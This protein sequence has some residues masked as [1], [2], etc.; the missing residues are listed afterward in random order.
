M[1]SKDTNTSIGLGGIV[2]V[3]FLILKLAGIVDWSW[4]WITAPL[5]LPIV[6][7]IAIGTVAALVIKLLKR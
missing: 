4:W 5:W 6:L 2:F 1:N 7:L 3:V